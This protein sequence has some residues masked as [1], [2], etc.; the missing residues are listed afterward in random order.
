MRGCDQIVNKIVKLYFQGFYFYDGKVK[1]CTLY[2]NIDDE[3][4]EGRFCESKDPKNRQEIDDKFILYFRIGNSRIRRTHLIRKI[5]NQNNTLRSSFLTPNSQ[6]VGVTKEVKTE[7]V[8]LI[9]CHLYPSTRI[10]SLVENVNM[11]AN[12]YEALLFPNFSNEISY[13]YL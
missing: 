9:I 12:D 7:R 11:I 1:A 2:S 5:S 6:F 8:I 10:L 4:F 3:Y 13:I